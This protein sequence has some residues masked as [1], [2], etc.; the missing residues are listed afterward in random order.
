MSDLLTAETWWWLSF[1]DTMRPRGDRFLGVSIVQ[2]ADIVEA[3][4]AAH[5]K[6]CNPGGEVQGAP[7]PEMLVPAAENRWRLL[8][9]Y[10]ATTLAERMDATVQ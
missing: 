9:K 7:I 1:V 2:G 6:D 3:A 5:A 4:K 10:E 8:S